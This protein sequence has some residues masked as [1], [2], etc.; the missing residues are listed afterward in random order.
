MSHLEDG[1][2]VD[3]SGDHLRLQA[4]KRPFGKGKTLLRGLSNRGS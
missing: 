1:L 2:P 4:I 3:V